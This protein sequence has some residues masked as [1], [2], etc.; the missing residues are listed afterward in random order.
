MDIKILENFEAYLMAFENKDLQNYNIDM[1]NK[2]KSMKEILKNLKGSSIKSVQNELNIFY[3]SEEKIMYKY[4]SQ[5]KNLFDKLKKFEILMDKRVNFFKE[6]LKE[7]KSKKITDILYIYNSIEKFPVFAFLILCNI[8]SSQFS[9]KN[10][11]EYVRL[12]YIYSLG[13]TSIKRQITFSIKNNKKNSDYDKTKINLFLNDKDDRIKDLLSEILNI[14]EEIELIAIHKKKVIQKTKNKSKYLTN[15]ISFNN[16]L[17]SISYRFSFKKYNYPSLI[18]PEEWDLNMFLTEESSYEN[19]QLMHYNLNRTKSNIVT[20]EALSI[21]NKTQEQKF[22]INTKQL[23]YI[24]LNINILIK[25]EINLNLNEY[26]NL[27]DYQN[28]EFLKFQNMETLYK[29]DIQKILIK[30]YQEKLLKVTHILETIYIAILFSKYDLYFSVFLDS[31]GRLYYNG[32]LL[33]PQGTVLA[34]SLLMFENESK[35]ISLDVRSSGFQI[36]GLLFKNEKLLKL[37]YLLENNTNIDL[38]TYL[39]NKF[40]NKHKKIINIKNYIDLFT[41]DFLNKYK[42]NSLILNP[43][44]KDRSIMKAICI[45][46]IYGQG[47]RNTTKLIKELNNLE[48]NTPQARVLAH[49]LY[50][51]LNEELKLV[52]FLKSMCYRVV[53]ENV[54]LK[55]GQPIILYDNPRFAIIS[56]YYVK[57]E[58]KKCRYINFKGETRC[59]TLMVDVKPFELDLSKNCKSI[60]ANLFHSIDSLILFRVLFL[61]HKQN[62]PIY[63]IHDCFVVPEQYQNIIQDIYNEVAMQV[64]EEDLLKNFIENNLETPLVEY[65]LKELK[66]QQQ[67]IK[68]IIFNQKPLKIENYIE[69]IKKLISN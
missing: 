22:K 8:I 30:N 51:F 5:N 15:V 69:E 36:L 20:T 49:L 21:I 28:K 23:N 56:Q 26:E 13:I 3:E 42:N 53:E 39:L 35:L 11:E 18:K 67:N 48:Y 34:K 64:Y 57:Q 43:K 12:S 29:N 38:Y 17:I 4:I 54:K 61:V 24:L 44:L 58:K 2:Y 33:T 66:Y 25:K 19:K 46:F 37:T 45:P 16:D 7:R 1:I 40:N 32:Y 59:T 55:P 50:N 31:R 14:F 65:Y 27:T 60:L 9:L 52:K 6:K 63:T 41:K 10:N 47:E 68:N 62:I